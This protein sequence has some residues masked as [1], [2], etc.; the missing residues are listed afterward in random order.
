M[1]RVRQKNPDYCFVACLASALLD[2][3]YDK[4]QDLIIERFPNELMQSPPQ[5]SA[6]RQNGRIQ[7]E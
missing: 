4:L 7:K 5:R 2:E 6:S 3:G 1:V